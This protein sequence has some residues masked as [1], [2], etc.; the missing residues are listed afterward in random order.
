KSQEFLG[1]EEVPLRKTC[2]WPE[3][4]GTQDCARTG[5][6]TVEAEKGKGETAPVHGRDCVA[7]TSGTAVSVGPRA[8]EE[9]VSGRPHPM[10]PRI[11]GICSLPDIL[12]S[13]VT[14]EGEELGS[15]ECSS[16]STDT[17]SC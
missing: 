15:L 8:G 13:V 6:P 16:A 12:L 11:K 14:Q 3:H 4:R 2:L 7:P 5:A 1:N 17:V 10:S 9:R